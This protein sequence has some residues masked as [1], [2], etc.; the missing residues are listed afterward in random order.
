MILWGSHGW[1]LKPK[2][3]GSATF[4]SLPD[5]NSKLVVTAMVLGGER[6]K[7]IQEE[8]IKKELQKMGAL[9]QIG[10]TEEWFSLVPGKVHV[11][12]DSRHYG[13]A[14]MVLEDR[15][16]DKPFAV[17]VEGTVVELPRKLGEHKLVKHTLSSSV[18]SMDLY[19]A[20]KVEEVAAVAAE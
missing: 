18:A 13:H 7:P 1:M 2:P 12:H 16:E 6:G 14:E 17:N 4:V 19:L 9:G 5:L 15:G 20:F 11:L 8:L 10:V 3:A